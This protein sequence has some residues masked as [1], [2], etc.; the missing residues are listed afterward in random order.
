MNIFIKQRVIKGI[1]FSIRIRHYGYANTTLAWHWFGGKITHHVYICTKFT[2]FI[3]LNCW[4]IKESNPI[5]KSRNYIKY[6]INIA[7]NYILINNN[8]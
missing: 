1:I 6:P 2:I 4:T 7:L 5:Y 8:K 3:N